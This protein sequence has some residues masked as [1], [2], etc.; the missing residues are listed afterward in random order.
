MVTQLIRCIFIMCGHKYNILL[1]NYYSIFYIYQILY[2]FVLYTIDLVYVIQIYEWMAMINILWFQK[3]KSL[4]VLYYQLRNKKNRDEW[5]RLGF[6]FF[7]FVRLACDVIVIITEISCTYLI[8]IP[9][10][11]LFYTG[12]PSLI[13]LIIKFIV[14]L[15]LFYMMKKYANYE[16]QR[17][18]RTLCIY[19]ILDFLAY[20]LAIIVFT[21]ELWR[22]WEMFPGTK[23]KYQ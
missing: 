18:K 6:Y 13:T 10:A 22:D 7:S 16:Y 11:Y 9:H 3:N 1:M 4:G 21:F 20:S 15:T 23:L 19:F 14:A 12:I 2:I 5:L 8:Y 17:C